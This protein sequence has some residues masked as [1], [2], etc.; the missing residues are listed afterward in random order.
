MKGRKMRKKRKKRLKEGVR[1]TQLQGGECKKRGK[2][3]EL[4]WEKREARKEKREAR[5]EK[6]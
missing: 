1:E 6:R 3:R 2:G 4:G 5:R